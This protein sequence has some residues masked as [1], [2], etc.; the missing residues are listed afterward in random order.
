MNHEYTLSIIKPD[1]TKRNITGK[2]NLYIE[3]SGLQIVAQKML[4]LTQ[5]Q[6]QDFYAEHKARPFYHDLV[7]YMISSPVIIQVLK[8]E[9]AVAKNRQVM[10]ATD[11][12]KA[13]AGTI[14]KDF[15]LSIEANTVHGSDSA[16]SAKRE[17]SFFFASCEICK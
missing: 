1:A 13:E 3:S 14:R 11:P 9:N 8:G 6:A 7:S 2:I 5:E 15:G 12:A 10:G 16:D 17:I 4:K